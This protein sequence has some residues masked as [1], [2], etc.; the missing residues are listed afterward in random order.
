LEYELWK[1]NYQTCIDMAQPIL[2]KELTCATVPSTT[3]S[4]VIF[5]QMHLN[6]LEE[7]LTLYKT[8]I[9]ELED[10]RANLDHYGKFIMLLSMTGNHVPAKELFIQQYPYVEAYQ[11]DFYT[12]QFYIGVLF[13]LKTLQED[14]HQEFIL[15]ETLTLPVSNVDNNYQVSDLTDYFEQEVDKIAEAFNLRNENGFY[16]GMK[17]DALS[18]M[19]FK[20]KVNL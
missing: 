1:G 16:S 4:K 5:A 11:C 15:P 8:A 17:T 9:K 13:F 6:Q 2:A 10:N 3:Y 14:G 12:I 7:A 20:R 19:E 18:L